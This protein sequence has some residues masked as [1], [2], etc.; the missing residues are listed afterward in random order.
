MQTLHWLD[1]TVPLGLTGLWL[2]FF[3]TNLRSRPLI[4]LHEP[5]LREALHHE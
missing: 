3:L 4:P 5:F 2:A 1:I